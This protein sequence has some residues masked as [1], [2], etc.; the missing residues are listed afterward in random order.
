MDNLLKNFYNENFDSKEIPFELL[1]IEQKK[2]IENSN[3]YQGYI[4]QIKLKNAVSEFKEP[5]N[6]KY[7]GL[8][9]IYPD[10]KIWLQTIS[11]DKS[12]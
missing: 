1:S 6:H 10:E 2:E 11:T 3:F 7:K 12:H 9:D 4:A 8:L 5:F